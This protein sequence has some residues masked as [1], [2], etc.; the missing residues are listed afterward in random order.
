MG[1]KNPHSPS[2][3]VSD[4]ATLLG[5]SD[6]T[7]RRWI[8][9][10]QVHAAKDGSGPLRVDGADL[11]AFLVDQLN[12]RHNLSD[13]SQVQSIRNHI[14]GIVTAVTSDTVMSRVELVTGGLRIVSLISTEAVQELGLQ[15]GSI[16]V[17]QV[18]ATNVSLQLPETR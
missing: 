2:H 10:G 6:D 1:T 9:L 15:V 11:A 18:K 16:A 5:V 13:A 17:D 12:G 14:Q 3:R 7:V 8:E 4:V